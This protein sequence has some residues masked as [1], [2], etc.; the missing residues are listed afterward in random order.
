MRV[1]LAWLRDYVEL[2]LDAQAVAD[3]LAGLGF[4]VD[5]LETRPTITGVV[6]GK[7]VAVEKHPNADRLQVCSIDTGG[8][9]RLTIATAATNVA[10]GQIVPIATIGAQLPNLRIERRTMRG[11]E[12]QGMMCSADELALPPDWFEDGIMQLDDACPLGADVVD[13]FGLGDSVLEVDITSN[14]VDAMSMIGL[15]RELAASEALPLRLP[16]FENPGVADEA[17]E[18]PRVT[19]ESADC[20][21]FVAQRFANVTVA[22]APARMRVR[23]ALAGQRPINNVVD[24][25]NYVMLEC[26]QPLH[27]YDDNK[28]AEHHLIV[29]DAKPGERLV[30]LDGTEYELTPQALVIAG[31]NE[32]EGLAGLKG[33]KASEVTGA[34]TC[35]LLESATFNGPR[36]RRTSTALGLR[37]EASTRHEKTLAPVLS[38]YGAGRAAQLLTAM[39]AN[40]LEPHVFGVPLRAAEPIVFDVRNVRRLLGF[41]LPLEEIREHLDALGFQVESADAQ[42]LLVTSPPWRLDVTIA[43]DLVE[44]I[45]RMAGYDRLESVIPA[46]VEHSIPSHGYNLERVLART[47]AGLGYREIISYAMHGADVFKKLRA[48]GIDPSANSVEVR[49]PL[50]EDQRYLRY[51]LGP[52]MLE[53]FARVDAPARVFEVGH[54]FY[55]EERTPAEAPT[56]AFGFTAKPI[57]E[58]AWRDTHFLRI[59]GDG[60]A[61]IRKLTGRT[62]IEVT[63]DVRNGLHPGKI[64][65]LMLDG[66]EIA[67]VGRIDPRVCAAF[68]VR[69]PAYVCSMYLENIPEYRTPKYAPPSK[70]PST[71]RDLAL[72]CSLETG[73]DAIARTIRRAV[74]SLCTGARAF[75]EYRGGTLDANH[76]SV[77]VRVTLQ[78]NDATITD[79]EAD[80]AI[81]GAL[82]ALERDL[83]AVIRS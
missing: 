9:E 61:L 8:A 71:Y 62:D 59:K 39:G 70:Y 28:I 80:A 2:P 32:I 29:R 47:L 42:T 13:L 54:V 55:L 68:D 16:S 44:E 15:A 65:V 12:S 53:H 4:P 38:D 49:N 3:R 20:A 48:G 57:D 67:N 18:A 21:R 78:R 51:A 22:A 19:I 7:I 24:V 72:V 37:T 30:T 50:S 17:A 83:G 40:A 77:A 1:P 63:R 5:T 41:T 11:I 14:R 43:A 66:H 31:E 52:A 82:A 34:T 64:A 81:A 6:V 79:E 10:A 33:G 75:D 35:I 36:I 56:L 25:S 27:F 76:K 26:G 23:L 45:A 69:L 58:P 74:G 73:A 60:E 46:V